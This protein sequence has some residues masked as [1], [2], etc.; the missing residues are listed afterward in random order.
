MIS[1]TIWLLLCG[2]ICA[3]IARQKRRSG[4]LWFFL[5]ILGGVF[6]VIAIAA[7]PSRKEVR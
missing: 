3:H 7:V 2:I 4:V 6:A 5:G 1:L